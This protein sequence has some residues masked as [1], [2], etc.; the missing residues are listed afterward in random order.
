[1]KR[2][3]VALAAVFAATG[4]TGP[5]VNVTDLEKFAAAEP[6]ADEI[7]VQTTSAL[8]EPRH[9][10][11]DVP[12]FGGISGWRTEW[13]LESHTCKVDITKAH[14]FFV[15]QLISLDSLTR[16]RK[17]RFTRVPVCM[18]IQNLGSPDRYRSGAPLVRQDSVVLLAK[19]SDNPWQ[20]FNLDAEGR[21]RAALDDTRCLTIGIETFE[22]GNRTPSEFW[23]RRD[24]TFSACTPDKAERQTWRVQK[25]PTDPA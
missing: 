11:L 20:R 16:D 25:P 19:C 8:D 14:Y 6:T 5:G 22:A 9:F 1:M 23:R 18:E 12:G 24:L 13:P 4:A 3:I 2:I 15:D 7:F 17:I 21:I 10:C